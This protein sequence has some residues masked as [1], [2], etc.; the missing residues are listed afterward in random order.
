ME[1]PRFEY[2][3]TWAKLKLDYAGVVT[4]LIL[5]RVHDVELASTSDSDTTCG[6]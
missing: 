5:L 3:Y 6:Y 1:L 2:V 4:L